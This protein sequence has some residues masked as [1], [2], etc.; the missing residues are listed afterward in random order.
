MRRPREL[1]LSR[2]FLT[3]AICGPHLVSTLYRCKYRDGLSACITG[4]AHRMCERDT[5]STIRLLRLPLQKFVDLCTFL[6]RP[7]PC[8]RVSFISNVL[9]SSYQPDS[10]V[11]NSHTVRLLTSQGVVWTVFNP[12]HPRHPLMLTKI[13]TKIF[14]TKTTGTIS[15]LAS[16]ALIR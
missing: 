5:G 3:T 4:M 16:M 7:T 12:S 11:I 6:A 10:I 8:W 9:P 1:P 13:G 15:T 14:L 2:T